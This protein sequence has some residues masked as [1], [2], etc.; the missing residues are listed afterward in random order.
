[1][2]ARNVDVECHCDPFFGHVRG[3]NRPL[4]FLSGAFWLPVTSPDASSADDVSTRRRSSSSDAD[5]HTPS[6]NGSRSSRSNGAEGD[7]KDDDKANS[8]CRSCVEKP[9]KQ[10]Q[11]QRGGG[12]G[13]NSSSGNEKDKRSEERRVRK[14]SKKRW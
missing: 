6:S 11:K 12:R 8:D 9:L 4:R 5:P 13:R 3:G 1:M 10:E 14:K 2:R 7:N